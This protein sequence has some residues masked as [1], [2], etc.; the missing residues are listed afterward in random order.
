MSARAEPRLPRSAWSVAAALFALSVLRMAPSMDWLDSPNLAASA[1]LMGVAHPPGEAGWLIPARLLQLIPVGDL[2]FRAN[3]LSAAALSLCALPLAAMLRSLVAT[4]PAGA[5]AASSGLVLLGFGAQLQGVRTE[6]YALTLLLLLGAAAA[7]VALTGRRASA[8]LGLLLGAAATVHPLLAAAATPALL[9]MRWTRGPV[10]IVDAPL[11]I[12]FG[13]VSFA[14]YAWLPLRALAVPGRSWGVPS[15]PAAFVDV[16]LARNFA[17]N[18]GE[19]GSGD[20]WVDNLS[21]IAGVHADALGVP[22]LLL[23]GLGWVLTAGPAR[24]ALAV[25]IPLWIAGNAAT[26]LPQN[27]VFPTNPDLLGYLVVGSAILGP[28]AAAALAQGLRGRV[29]RVPVI[30]W[31]L[32]AFGLAYLL[33]LQDADRSH[34]EPARRFATEMAT[35]LPPGAILI[36]SGNDGAFAWAHLQGVERRR[37]DLV[38]VPRV[39]L[40][41]PQ[42]EV[43]LGGAARFEL[44]TGLAWSP[45]TQASPTAAAAAARRPLYLEVRDP[46]LD[47]LHDGR[48]LPHGLVAGWS[49]VANLHP[50]PEPPALRALRRAALNELAAAA[51][52]GDD[53]AGLVR[54]LFMDLRGVE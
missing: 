37:A 16:L 22:L 5:V 19:G 15:T 29:A 39:L 46:E 11:A 44:E 13:L 7:C 27:K 9:A 33:L 40:G 18:F 31:G 14:A 30:A 24:R 42:E 41:H 38:V 17:R 2:A 6:V 48:L 53:E 32:F 1:F 28:P 34:H 23:A 52:A 45:A 47:A 21:T 4:P 25:G 51:A 8:A 49:G 12:G 36:P 20:G 10:R 43:R 3:L 54:A 26:I 35:H 50:P